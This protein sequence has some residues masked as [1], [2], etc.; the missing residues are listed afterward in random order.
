MEK[1][2]VGSP[3]GFT[4]DWLLLNMINR[5]ILDYY[6]LNVCNTYTDFCLYKLGRDKGVL[7]TEVHIIYRTSG[8]CYRV[9]S[10]DFDCCFYKTCRNAGEVCDYLISRFIPDYVCPKSTKEK[11]AELRERRRERQVYQNTLNEGCCA[12]ETDST[13]VPNPKAFSYMSD[14]EN[15]KIGKGGGFRKN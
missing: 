4:W 15:E 9:S 1:N 10:F 8:A 13:A 2:N 7:L 3:G 12:G 14:M 11:L 5:G 6:Q